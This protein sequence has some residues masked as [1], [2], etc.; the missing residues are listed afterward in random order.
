MK[1]DGV[2]AWLKHWL[3]MQNKGSRPLVLKDRSDRPFEAHAKRNPVVV[4]R[5]K[6]KKR[7]VE[8][9]ES[10]EDEAPNVNDG[11]SDVVGTNASTTASVKSLPKS[12]HNV[13]SSRKGRRTFL[14]SLSTHKDYR[15]LLLLL[16]AAKVRN[17]LLDCAS[18]DTFI[19]W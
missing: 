4:D 5:R 7:Q 2:D 16:A 12:P 17:S 11:A 9:V 15:N 19:G 6:G 13:P 3:K 8:Y 10:D 18:T 14:D 1:S